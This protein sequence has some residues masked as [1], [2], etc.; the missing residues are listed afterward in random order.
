MEKL[1]KPPKD[2]FSHLLTAYKGWR[3]ADEVIPD[4]RT[5]RPQDIASILP[6]VM[7]TDYVSE[8]LLE[9]RLVGEQIKLLY[10]DIHIE[11]KDTANFKPAV[12]NQIDLHRA[13]VHS[14][15]HDQCGV[16]TQRLLR[17]EKGEDW[18]YELM[19]LPLKNTATN[20]ASF[21][22]AINLT[23]PEKKTSD[24]WHLPHSF[25]IQNT[26]II[27]ITPIDLGQGVFDLPKDLLSDVVIH[28]L[29]SH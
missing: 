26:V 11:G 25:D 8:Q 21:I 19:A 15:Q 13:I 4:R 14:I 17:E 1:I 6:H 9:Y 20:K 29:Y 10:G 23:L 12:S 22:M 28:P 24:Y 2:I 3:T 16:V 27:G 5:I 18:L 7:I